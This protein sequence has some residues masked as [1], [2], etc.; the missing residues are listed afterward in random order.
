MSGIVIAFMLFDSIGKW[1]KPAVVVEG[2]LSLGF[3][4]HHIAL[5]GTLGFIATV[6]YAIPRTSI[7]GAVL[8]T[9]FFGGVVASQIRVDAPL[10]T[11]I[12]FAVYLAVLAWGG[13]WLRNENV[14][15]LVG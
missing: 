1:M 15:K 12:L 13:L 8:L 7:L 9:G 2:T 3:A 4:E 5:I 14:R 10:F 11:N 6:L